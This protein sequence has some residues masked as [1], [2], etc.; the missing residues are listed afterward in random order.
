VNVKG[1]YRRFPKFAL[2]GKLS[3]SGMSVLSVHDPGSF[4]IPKLDF[5]P[6]AV[7]ADQL[8]DKAAPPGDPV[9]DNPGR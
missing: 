9:R 6:F 7:S 8:P 1:L 2:I 5:C 4:A 3:P